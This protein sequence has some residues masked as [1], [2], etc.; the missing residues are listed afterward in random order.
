MLRLLAGAGFLVALAT[1]ADAITLAPP[2]Q[3]HETITQAAYRCGAGRTRVEGVCKARTTVRH[4]RRA[5]RAV[6]RCVGW[7]RGVCAGWH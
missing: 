2:P 4:T 3:S 6:R 7:H 5:S 1:S